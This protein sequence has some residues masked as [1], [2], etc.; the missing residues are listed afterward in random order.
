M[1]SMLNDT[2]HTVK[3]ALDSAREGGEHAIGAARQGTERA[4]S[5][6]RS[7]LLDAVHAVTGLVAMLRRLD[8]DDALGWV[9]LARRRSP[10]A[11]MMAFGAGI[12]VGTGVGVMLAPSSGAEL[13]RTIL[14]RLTGLKDEAKATAEQAASSVQEMAEKTGDAV[15]K[16]EQKIETKVAAGADAVKSAEQKLETK[17]AAGADAVKD[18]VKQAADDARAANL[19]PKMQGNGGPTHSH[20]S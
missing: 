17:V 16:V 13:R 4:V 14:K 18:A 8:G 7:S 6:T 9:G 20:H 10:L 3:N 15:K 19:T 11:S 1:E 12:V 5:T 2:I